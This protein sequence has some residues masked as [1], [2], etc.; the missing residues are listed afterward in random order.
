MIV[1]GEHVRLLGTNS[2][3][4]GVSKSFLKPYLKPKYFFEVKEGEIIYV[5]GDEPSEIFLI[6]EGEVKIKFSCNGNG[7]GNG[8]A[9]VKH[10]FL[11]DFF[12]EDEILKGGERIS[13]AVAET[14]CVLFKMN[15][16]ELKQLSTS[17]KKIADNLKINDE[18]ENDVENE[19]NNDI[20]PADYISPMDSNEEP[21]S[22]DLPQENFDDDVDW[23]LAEG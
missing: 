1:D 4:K 15:S 10:K 20:N 19:V 22:S 9:N 13:S 11:S 16:A 2:L 8:N 3:F 5:C 14:D 23:K 7:N 12:G 17:D 18:V 21:G 6:V